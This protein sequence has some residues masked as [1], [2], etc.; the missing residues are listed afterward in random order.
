MFIIILSC[1]GSQCVALHS[2]RRWFALLFVPHSLFFSLKFLLLVVNAS[3]FLY[4]I[5]LF[6]CVCSDIAVEVNN[7]MQKQEAFKT[8]CKI[9]KTF[10][11]L[12]KVQTKKKNN[13]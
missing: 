7:E 13:N 4:S 1:G 12:T 2:L 9:E 11:G 3:V 6:L 5:F 8:V 10:T